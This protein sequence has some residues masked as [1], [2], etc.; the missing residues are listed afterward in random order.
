MLLAAVRAAAA[1]VGLCD[2]AV[3]V[4]VVVLFEC[5][6]C[7]HVGAPRVRAG[8]GARG[9]DLYVRRR[10]FLIVRLLL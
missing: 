7:A 5:I 4:V 1:P 10:L 3:Q 6:L 2:V 8:Q 9:F